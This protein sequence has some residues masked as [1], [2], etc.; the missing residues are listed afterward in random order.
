VVAFVL[1]LASAGTIVFAQ[2]AASYVAAWISIGL[3]GAVIIVTAL[4][5]ALRARP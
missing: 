2:L 5:L 3:S 1:L 4:A